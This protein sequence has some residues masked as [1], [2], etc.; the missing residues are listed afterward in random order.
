MY[1][2]SEFLLLSG[3]QH[4][5]F[6][7][8]QCALIHIE[9]QWTENFFTAAGRNQHQKVHDG[10]GESRKNVRTE[11]NLS[12]A[13]SRLGISGKTDAV[14]F[15]A[16][17]KIVPVEYKHGAPKNDTCDEVQLCAQ[18]ICLE[19]ML[20]KK[21]SVGALFYFKTKKRISVPI[22]D[23]LR[24]ETENLARGFHAL[25][26]SGKTPMAE[27]SRKCESCSFVD[28][29]FPESAGKNKSVENYIKRRIRQDLI[30]ED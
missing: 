1:A 17:G 12:I 22:T 7:P 9:R 20:G 19:E 24:A 3:I 27:Y 5:R 6:C 11:R 28:S 14:E 30:S 13:S 16:D 21:I 8:R 4:F 23:D 15:Y 18:A 10:S 29:C 2:E 25:V 26:E